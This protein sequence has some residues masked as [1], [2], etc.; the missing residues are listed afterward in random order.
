MVGEVF[1][2]CLFAMND[3]G[4][5]KRS[6]QTKDTYMPGP[7]AGIRVLEVASIGPGPFCAMML[8]DMG[9]EVIRI[10]RRADVGRRPWVPPRADILSRGRRSLALDLKQPEGAQVLLDMA[11]QADLLVKAFAP[12]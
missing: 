5:I 2:A 11:V 10:D 3:F 12:A 7:L 1:G 8:A 9:A 6:T 4:R